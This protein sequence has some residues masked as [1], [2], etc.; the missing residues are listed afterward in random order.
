MALPSRKKQIERVMELLDS[1]E[2]LE[3]EDTAVRIVDGY[4]Q[5]IAPKKIPPPP[6]HGMA[7]VTPFDNH[8]HFIAWQDEVKC[9]VVSD[10]SHYGQWI[11]N[12]NEFFWSCIEVSPD[13]RRR[14]KKVRTLVVDE[15][16]IAV[17]DPET[18]D[19]AF[20]EETVEVVLGPRPGEP[21]NNPDWRVGDRVSLSQRLAEY[22]I[23]ATGDECV[24]MQDLNT[25]ELQA[26]SNSNM[27]RY[28]R[29]EES[30]H[31]DDF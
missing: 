13:R 27:K 29:R 23:I 2:N 10:E 24:L 19:P 7:F 3:L 1:E 5:A 15:D 4:H 21:G 20:T 17:I 14:S 28:Y 18:G 30:I 26:D 31:D 6:H 22:E 11:R 9:W 25:G 12:D 8:V 16:G